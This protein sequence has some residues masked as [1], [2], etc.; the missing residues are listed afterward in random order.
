[1]SKD[2]LAITVDCHTDAPEDFF[3]ISTVETPEVDFLLYGF[4]DKPKELYT[5]EEFRRVVNKV[6][7]KRTS[8]FVLLVM[9]KRSGKS[10]CFVS[11]L[12][13]LEQGKI[14]STHN[15]IVLDLSLSK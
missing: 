5:A 14:G 1:M 7:F 13:W 4:P 10:R 2:L 6:K 15:R 9:D 3:V 8:E 11:P 12:K